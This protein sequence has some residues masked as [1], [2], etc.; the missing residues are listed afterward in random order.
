MAGKGNP[1]WVKGVSGNPAGRPKIVKELKARALKAV[2]EYVFKAWIEELEVRERVV[3]I[4]GRELVVRE[5]GPN[6]VRCSE[7][8]ANYGM[9]KPTQPVSG[10]D[11]DDPPIAIAIKFVGG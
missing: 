6:W 3:T 5:R 10:S 9:G 2:D 8:L 1:N 7:L 11:E 4:A